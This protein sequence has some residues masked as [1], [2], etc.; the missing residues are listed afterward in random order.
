MILH[1]AQQNERVWE[2][3]SLRF[4]SG[5]YP[6]SGHSRGRNT[7]PKDS[8]GWA[9]GCVILLL[10]KVSPYGRTVDVVAEKPVMGTSLWSDIWK[11][12]VPLASL[13]VASVE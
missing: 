11:H 7:A 10:C 6:L 5:G 13:P 12:Q 3:A 4:S 1:G 9:K 8:W 2:K